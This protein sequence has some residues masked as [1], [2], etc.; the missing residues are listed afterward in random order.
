MSPKQHPP[1]SEAIKYSKGFQEQTAVCPHCGAISLFEQLK[2]DALGHR[3]SGTGLSS[4]DVFYIGRCVGCD[5]LVVAVYG[6]KPGQESLARGGRT[7]LLWPVDTPPDRAPP[8]LDGDTRRSYDE[9]R[10]ILAL[11]PQAAAVLA[12]RCLQRVI[13]EKLDITK[14][15]LFDEIAEAAKRHELS[16]PTCQALDDVRTLGNWGAHPTKDEADTIIEVTPEEARYTLEVLEMVFADLY[17]APVRAAEMKRRIKGRKDGGAPEGGDR[18]GDTDV[19][20]GP[21][22]PGTGLSAG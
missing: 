4:A 8:D 19:G 5:G 22:P 11:S 7:V 20:E 14:G 2:S 10:R 18:N 17:V 6:S 9:A 21:A 1:L 16:R 15:R 12:R 13:R 3:V